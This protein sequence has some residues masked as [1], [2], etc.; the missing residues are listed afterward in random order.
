M[1]VRRP[2]FDSPLK[3]VRKLWKTIDIAHSSVQR[4]Q[5]ILVNVARV[6]DGLDEFAMDDFVVRSLPLFMLHFFTDK[7]GFYSY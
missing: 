4:L 2:F 3:D 6:P 7:G 5:Q 1:L